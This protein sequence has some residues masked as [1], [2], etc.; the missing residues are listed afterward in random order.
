MAGEE[1]L[2]SFIKPPAAPAGAAQR[3]Q[4]PAA[5]PPPPRQDEKLIARIAELE[6]KIKLLET[7]DFGPGRAAVDGLKTELLDSQ[8]SICG[9]E[10]AI[11]GLRKEVEE[12]GRDKQALKE[13]LSLATKQFQGELSGLRYRAD[14]VEEQFRGL[15]LSDLDGRLS[16]R[17][18]KQVEGGV[19]SEFRDRFSTLD[20]A[21]GQVAGKA[22]MA[23]ETSAGSARRVD[24][25]E[26]RA[27]AISYLESRL[28]SNEKRIEK[29]Y[30]L[31][32]IVQAMKISVESV[33][34]K[35]SV[36]IED[37]A[38]ISAENKKII[39]DFE[40]LSHQVKQLTALF[41]YFRTELAFLLPKKK[42]SVGEKL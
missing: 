9:L 11:A 7:K 20:A 2:F 10:N 4:A 34:N 17:V 21:F 5:P 38:G 19:V 35:F 42:D 6:A 13:S 18:L 32:A 28:E 33:E 29:T 26:E 25:L 40:S 22:N 39:S 31:E 30:D 27:A 16:E 3:A 1:S 37:T 24:K 14:S 12:A 23:Y 36:A 15:S 8:R 41:N